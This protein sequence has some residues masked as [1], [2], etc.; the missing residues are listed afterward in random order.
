LASAITPFS[1]PDVFVEGLQKGAP[2]RPDTTLS[3]AGGTATLHVPIVGEPA[4]AI[5]GR[6]LK[7]TIVDGARAAETEIAPVLGSLPPLRADASR[8][9][10]FG[11][12]LLGG[13]ILN[14]M[15]CVLPVLSL[16]LLTLAGYAGAKRHAARI[17]LLATAAGVIVSFALLAAALIALKAAGSAIGWGIQFQQPWF[18]A[19]MALVTSLFAASLWGWA[20]I[21]LPTGVADAIGLVRSYGRFSN[22]FLTGVFATLLAAS[23]SAPF[24]GTAIGFAL[25]RGP[26]DIAL[27]FGAL[28]LGMAAPFLAIAALPGLV[29]YL[30]RPGRWMIWLERILGVALIG[31]AAWLLSLLALEAGTELALLTG[32]LLALLSAALAWRHHR[33]TSG[34]AKRPLGV[35]AV[36][37]AALAVLVPALR[38]E[39]ISM[40]QIGSNAEAGQWQPFDKAALHRSVAAGKTVL[41]DVTAAWCLTCKANE[42]AV[43]DRSPV[44][45]RLH[46]P[47]VVAMRADWTRADPVITAY[48]QSFGRYGVPLDVV[49]GP[50]APQGIPLPELL[51]SRVVIDAFTRAAGSSKEEARE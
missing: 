8:I 36:G 45:D 16:K 21:I 28:G 3:G 31:T 23:C 33:S 35:V 25:A 7:V 2:G 39:A 38:S 1:S 40:K 4:A 11:L 34:L 29:A 22:A 17:G 27:V 42:L 14:L 15:P 47:R 10:I 43:F 32:V 50:G 19:G 30:P 49:Y 6:N 51:S 9:A 41:V 12:A 13:L 18:L 37:L 20:P 24:V 26:T 48:L 44:A 5:A 46:D